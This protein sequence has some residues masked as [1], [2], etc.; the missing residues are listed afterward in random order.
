MN[1]G[2]ELDWQL[3]VVRLGQVGHTTFPNLDEKILYTATVLPTIWTLT[4]LTWQ[5]ILV[6]LY[7]SSSFP[8]IEAFL[9]SEDM[10]NL[11]SIIF[12]SLIPNERFF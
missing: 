5:S 4:A 11:L 10:G 2:Q 12:P 7:V 1:L 9:H 8:S 3:A 6:Q